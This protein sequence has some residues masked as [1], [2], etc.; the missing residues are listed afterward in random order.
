MQTLIDLID[1]FIPTIIGQSLVDTDVVINF[2]LDLRK[3]INDQQSE[4]SIRRDELRQEASDYGGD[5]G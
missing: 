1:D 3:V 4:T 2:C 5:S